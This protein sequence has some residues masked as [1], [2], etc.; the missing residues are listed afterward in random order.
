[1]LGLS[2]SLREELAPHG[3]GVTAVCPGIINTPIVRNSRWRGGAGSEEV[4]AQAAQ[5]FARRNYPPERV[6][7]NVLAA[8]QRNRAVAP[9]SP[10]AWTFYYLKRF[11]PGLVR[12]ISAQVA[13][14]QPS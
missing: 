13:R 9:I 7:D 2:E 5:A 1:V 3:I 10:E 11:A 14:R 6:A 8:V 4:R 12:W